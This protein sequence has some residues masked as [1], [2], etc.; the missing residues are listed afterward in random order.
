MLAPVLPQH[1]HVVEKAPGGRLLSA[2]LWASL[3]EATTSI[4]AF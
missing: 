4:A 2:V 1:V 3:T